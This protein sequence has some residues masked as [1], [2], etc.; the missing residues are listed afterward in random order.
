M[1]MVHLLRGLTVELDLLGAEFANANRLHPTDLRALI[2]LLDAARASTAATPGWLGGQ[3]GLSSAS[4]TALID[5]LEEAGYVRRA[6]D[7]GDRR[8]VLL[9]VEEKAVALGWSFFGP[10]IT[11]M[12]AAMQSF[13]EA[14]LA[15]VRR[16]LLGMTTVTAARRQHDEENAQPPQPTKR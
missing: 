14:E 10:L 12:V 6:R 11:D 16:F 13:D 9:A 2:L 7:A 3:L 4:T 1:Q 5:R 15:T 8:R